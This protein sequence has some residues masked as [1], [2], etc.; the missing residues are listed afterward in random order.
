[1]N[2]RSFHD[3]YWRSLAPNFER[4][5]L[6]NVDSAGSAHTRANFFGCFAMTLK[7]RFPKLKL[8]HVDV[9]KPEIF[10]D[11]N[12][13]TSLER[14]V[15]S[16]KHLIPEDNLT[17]LFVARD[18]LPP[19]ITSLR[20]VLPDVEHVDAIVWNLLHDHN[21]QYTYDQ[22]HSILLRCKSVLQALIVTSVDYCRLAR[23]RACIYSNSAQFPSFSAA[24]YAATDLVPT[25]YCG[26]DLTQICGAR[27]LPGYRIRTIWQD[28]C[29]RIQACARE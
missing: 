19:N 11:L 10:Q 1:M 20:V 5:I 16:S 13:L 27:H 21:I 17:L 3:K 22:A 15:L 9:I 8:L 23:L 24:V 12:Q 7:K 2:I 6:K 29:T 25:R 4:L 26:F 18:R 28:I 14:L